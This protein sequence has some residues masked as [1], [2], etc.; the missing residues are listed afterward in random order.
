MKNRQNCKKQ[1]VTTG[2]G[3]GLVILALCVYMCVCV[4]DRNARN[5]QSFSDELKK[6]QWVKTSQSS[7]RESFEM[8]LRKRLPRKIWIQNG[9]MKTLCL[10][11]RIWKEIHLFWWSHKYSSKSNQIWKIF[12][13]LLFPVKSKH[14]HSDKSEAFRQ[15][16]FYLAN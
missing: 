10:K 7:N 3:K 9:F 14:P 1:E 13:L 5:W 11:T 6:V 12:L 15:T 2:N 16:G 4:S 8:S